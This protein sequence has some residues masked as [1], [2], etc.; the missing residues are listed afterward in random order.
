MGASW[1]VFGRRKAEKKQMPKYFKH[2]R[3]INGM[4]HGRPCHAAAQLQ[5]GYPGARPGLAAAG[6]HVLVASLRAHAAVLNLEL[7]FGPGAG[8]EAPTTFEDGVFVRPS[9]AADPRVRRAFERSWQEEAFRPLESD[10]LPWAPA[11][12][13]RWRAVANAAT[14]RGAH[15]LR[16]AGRAVALA[17][18]QPGRFDNPF[19]LPGGGL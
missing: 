4:A 1:A 15:L 8:A 18:V 19:L 3:N 7:V 9:E 14:Q 16:V 2:L 17:R 13:A 12:G 6:E 11:P 10:E 5:H